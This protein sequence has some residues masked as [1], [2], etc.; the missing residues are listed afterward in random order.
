MKEN[1]WNQTGSAHLSSVGNVSE[2]V[3]DNVMAR[4][5]SPLD[6]KWR[7]PVPPAYVE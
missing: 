2:E 7:L 1:K 4:T 3:G 5:C 6:P